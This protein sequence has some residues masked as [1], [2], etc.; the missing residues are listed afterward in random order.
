MPAM[1]RID[2][3]QPGHAGEDGR[4]AAFASRGGRKLSAAL[5]A[6]GLDVAGWTCADF[7]AN[8]GG[9][10]D[11]LLRR[12]AA[13][14]FAVDTGHGA[15]T[16]RLRKHPRVVVMERTNALYVDPPAPDGVDLVVIDVAFTP[17]RRIVPAA[18]RW[19]RPGGRIVS[20]LKPHYELA[21]LPGAKRPRHG[22][23]IDFHVAAD[24]CDRVC[25]GLA[26][27]GVA[28]L[29]AMVS[30]LKGKGGNVEFFLHLRPEGS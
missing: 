6:F 1:S 8:V 16:W 4:G 12:G 19:L 15:L 23:P 18:V 26:E 21:K 3:P 22:K 9:F 17:Q 20:T 30:P 14:V 27:R 10:T 2:A 13:R 24:L 7:G 25:R 28:I 11:C 5:E 29:A